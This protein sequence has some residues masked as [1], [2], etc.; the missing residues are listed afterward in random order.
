MKKNRLLIIVWIWLFVGC[1][2]PACQAKGVKFSPTQQAANGLDQGLGNCI[3]PEHTFAYQTKGKWIPGTETHKVLPAE[4]WIIE[5]SMP[6]YPDIAI[7]G[8]RKDWIL[9]VFPAPN[10]SQKVWILRSWTDDRTKGEFSTMEV[11]VYDTKT[12]EWETLPAKV[13]GS[14]AVI[15]ELFMTKDGAIWAHNYWGNFFTVFEPPLQVGI[16]EERNSYQG[17]PILSKLNEKTKQFEPV[18]DTKNIPAGQLD[19]KWNKVILDQNGTFWIFVQNDGIYSYRPESAVIKRHAILQDGPD[20]I[21]VQ[22]AVLDSSGHI[23]F[24]NG[25]TAIFRFDQDTD[26]IERIGGSPLPFEGKYSLY[27]NGIWID[28]TKRLWV[29]NIGWAEPDDYHTWYQLLPSPIFISLSEG[30]TIYSQQAPWLIREG[31]DGRLW[32]K[33]G[34]GMTWLDP[35]LEKWC[36]FT[37]ESSNIVEDTQRNLWMVADNKVYELEPK[38]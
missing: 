37:T 10:G 14:Q 21:V 38:R 35:Q 19:E 12:K 27:F 7:E 1:S 23:F 30:D 9:A 20:R 29:G 22:T 6:E 11:L 28:H 24:S 8:T 25:T 5:A 13:K 17:M 2:L 15:G 18:E 34:N 16:S 33:S 36:W 31:V 32:Y 4:P 3:V 26:T